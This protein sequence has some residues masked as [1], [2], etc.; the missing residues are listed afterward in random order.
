MQEKMN[1]FQHDLGDQVMLALKRKHMENS[2]LQNEAHHLCEKESW[3]SQELHR[4]HNHLSESEESPTQELLA[5]EDRE[6]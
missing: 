5:M 2:V 4:L 6:A 1:A 3:L